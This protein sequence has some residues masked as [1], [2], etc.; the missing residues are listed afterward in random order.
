LLRAIARFFL[1]VIEALGSAA[2]FGLLAAGGW[3]IWKTYLQ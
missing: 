1:F 2:F 3:W